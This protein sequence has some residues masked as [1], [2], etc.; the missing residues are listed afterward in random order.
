[1]KLIG[2]KFKTNN[3]S[4]SWRGVTLNPKRWYITQL[5]PYLPDDGW[6]YCLS[7]CSR[8]NVQFWGYFQKKGDSRMLKFTVDLDSGMIL[9]QV[10]E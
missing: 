5:E 4:S 1:M 3:D 10:F 8:D 2:R 7:K 6:E 9:N